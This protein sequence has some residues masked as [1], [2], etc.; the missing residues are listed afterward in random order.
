MKKL[1]SSPSSRARARSASWL[2]IYLIFMTTRRCSR[3]S[4]S[5]R[6]ARRLEPVLQPE[7]LLLPRRARVH[8]VHR[9]VRRGHLRRS[10]SSWTRN[11]K[12]GRH[13]EPR[14]STSPSRSA[15]SCSSPARSGRRPP[16]DVWWNWEPRLTMSLLLWLILVG[17]VLVRRFAGP[18]GRPRRRRHGDLRHGRRA[19]HLHDGRPG[20]APGVGHATASSRRSAPG[21]LRRVLAR[22]RSTFL[23]WF[24]ALVDR[25]CPEHARRARGA[26]AARAA[27]SIW[28]CCNEE[29]V[30]LVRRSVI[31][32]VGAAVRRARPR[33]TCRRSRPAATLA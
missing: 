18:S 6:P 17:Y 27:G 13:R 33:A 24:I 15:R 2:S 12:L 28:E 1:G 21:M 31:L 16:W 5:G 10:S 22:R 14:R 4:T 30:V 26:R 29:A 20:L 9:G 23:L 32:R 8:A 3:A 19:V 25:A 7:D 11:P